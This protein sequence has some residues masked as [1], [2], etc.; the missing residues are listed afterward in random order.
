MPWT[1][2]ERE[3]W[4]EEQAEAVNCWMPCTVCRQTEVNAGDGEDTCREC[5]GRQ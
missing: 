1:D 5:L 4:T 2:A 3:D